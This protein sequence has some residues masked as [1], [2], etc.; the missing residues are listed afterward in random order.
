MALRLMILTF[1]IRGTS[2]TTH[3]IWRTGVNFIN[4]LRAAFT[5]AD[6]KS[7][8]NTVKLSAFLRFWELR[9]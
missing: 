7:A 4:A 8:E 1:Y 9:T 6:P 3:S 2:L 5:L